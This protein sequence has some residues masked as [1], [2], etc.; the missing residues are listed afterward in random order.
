MTTLRISVLA[1]ALGALALPAF[2]VTIPTPYGTIAGIALT[3]TGSGQFAQSSSQAGEIEFDFNLDNG[4]VIKGEVC[5]FGAATCVD[6]GT[7]ATFD[8][9]APELYVSISVECGRAN[10]AAVTYNL[11]ADYNMTGSVQGGDAIG[12]L[13]QSND[14][15][16]MNPS[17]AL[18]F[19]GSVNGSPI[20]PSG[21]FTFDP[22]G[23]SSSFP[24]NGSDGA[25]TF[26]V[27]GGPATANLSGSITLAG[28]EDVL[29]FHADVALTAVATP[30]PG[31][32][33][34]ILAGLGACV[35]AVR[36]RITL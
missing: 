10:C 3:G 26:N 19:L 36:K 18:T 23:G 8:P 6:N 4:E 13:F 9:S 29:N 11:S 20:N 16:G 14:I 30:E 2:A 25:A 34:L 21:G 27:G 1:A 7:G 33:S 24:T 5:S 12:G 17:D 15:A 28:P 35:F 32:L 22:T 31:S